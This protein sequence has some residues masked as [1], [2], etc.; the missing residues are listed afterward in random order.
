MFWAETDVK[1]GLEHYLGVP[2]RTSYE[3]TR[4]G[5]GR[6]VGGGAGLMGVL[7]AWDGTAVGWVVRPWPGLPTED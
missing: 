2:L 1:T 5:A 7:V 3:G 4:V 6:V